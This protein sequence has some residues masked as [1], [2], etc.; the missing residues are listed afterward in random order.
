M[1]PNQSITSM[2]GRYIVDFVAYMEMK[3]I[4]T[5]YSI[6]FLYHNSVRSYNALFYV[7]WLIFTM[8][9]TIHHIRLKKNATSL[10]INQSIYSP[11]MTTQQ[12]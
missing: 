1:E 3:G 7:L 4:T 12:V 11:S 9:Q 10:S 8:L 2:N 6:Y 5:R